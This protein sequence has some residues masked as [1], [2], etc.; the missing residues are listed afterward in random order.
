M[1]KK[2]DGRVGRVFEKRLKEVFDTL[3][4]RL[5]FDYHRFTD[6]KAAG[7]YVGTQPGDFMISFTSEGGDAKLAQGGAYVIILEVK[8]SE[9]KE[10]LRSCAASHILPAQIGKHKA[11]LRSGGYAHFWFYCESTGLVELWDSAHVVAQRSDGKPL[12]VEKRLAVFDYLTLEEELINYF[13][14]TKANRST[15]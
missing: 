4:K 7:R 10:S 5:G 12:L 13:G 15:S 11:W 8:A 14:L 2:D 3:K 1:S 6:T 9:E